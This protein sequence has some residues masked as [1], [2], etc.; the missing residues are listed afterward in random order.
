[1]ILQLVLYWYHIEVLYMSTANFNLRNIASNVMSM[2]KKKATQQ[3]ISVNSLIVQI[4]EQGLGIAHPT[5][6]VIFHDLDHLAGTWSD[7]DKKVFE[8]NI[9]SFEKIDKDLW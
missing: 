2:L 6:K 4:I 3:K 8:D 7:K 5:K 9:K 1:M